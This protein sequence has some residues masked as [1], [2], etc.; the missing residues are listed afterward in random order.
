[1]LN[2]VIKCHKIDGSTGSDDTSSS[3]ITSHDYF[4]QSSIKLF[5]KKIFYAII[6]SS[7]YVV[8]TIIWNAGRY[9]DQENRILIIDDENTALMKMKV[10]L[11]EYGVCEASNTARQ[12]LVMF[13]RAINNKRPFTLVTLDIEM[14]YMNGVE[15]MK[16]M[17]EI[18]SEQEITPSYKVM[19]TASSTPDNLK[20]SMSNSCSAFLVKP[21]KRNTIEETLKKLNIFKIDR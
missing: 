8:Q 4:F 20:A 16:K 3:I 2:Y 7:C 15:L 18:E 19:V 11:S 1:M 21:V 9:M 14:P 5:K 6:T 10:M 17:Y 13:I 12:G